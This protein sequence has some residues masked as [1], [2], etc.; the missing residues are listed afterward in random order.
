MVDTF[1]G[2]DA[3]IHPAGYDH[4]AAR[5]FGRF[6]E[7]GHQAR[8]RLILGMAIDH[9]AAITPTGQA[10]NSHWLIIDTGITDV[11]AV[12]FLVASQDVWRYGELAEPVD[13]LEHPRAAL[14]YPITDIATREARVRRYLDH[15]RTHGD[16]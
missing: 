1:D 6:M 11:G 10:D 8:R 15:I 7:D 4:E 3:G 12:A 14:D 2:D 9:E 16:G 5:Q 13:S